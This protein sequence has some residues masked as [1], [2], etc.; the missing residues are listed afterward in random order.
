MRTKEDIQKQLDKLKAEVRAELDK[1]HRPRW[2]EDACQTI[3]CLIQ[4]LEATN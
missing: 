4:E 3:R 1:G 2:I